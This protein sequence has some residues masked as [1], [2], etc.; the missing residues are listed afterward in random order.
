MMIVWTEKRRSSPRFLQSLY[1]HDDAILA[2]AANDRCTM[3]VA[4]AVVSIAL[5]SLVGCGASGSALPNG[6]NPGLP[7]CQSHGDCSS[8]LHSSVDCV[9]GQCTAR[10]M[11]GWADCDSLASTGCEADVTSDS[12]HCGRCDRDCVLGACLNGECLP[13]V[14]A[15]NQEKPYS[16]AVSDSQVYWGND[17]DGKEGTGALMTAP[18]SGGTA[19]VLVSGQW[20]PR[21]ILVEGEMVYWVNQGLPGG[22]TGAVI[23][24]SPISIRSLARAQRGPVGLTHSGPWLYWTNFGAGEIVRLALPNGSPQIVATGQDTPLGIAADPTGVYW[25][26]RNSHE[27]WRLDHSLAGPPVLLSQ[28]SAVNRIDL[29][30]NWLYL[31]GAGGGIGRL[32]LS[33]GQVESVADANRAYNIK[34]VAHSCFWTDVGAATV[35]ETDVDSRATKVIGRAERE[36][37]GLAADSRSVYWTRLGTG[38]VIGLTR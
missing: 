12:H 24:M 2:S 32:A 34:I 19:R 11:S 26:N 18:R 17:G 7:S 6:P 20:S 22:S 23:A 16:I 35:S 1:G 5:A 8:V 10:C 4:R 13:Y 28:S 29:D 36:P 15:S 21:D 38:E 33:G 14:V 9:G 25:S 3:R 27:L 37:Y 31:A 30:A